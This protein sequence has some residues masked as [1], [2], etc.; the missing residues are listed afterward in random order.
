MT[1]FDEEGHD[2]TLTIKTSHQALNKPEVLHYDLTVIKLTLPLDFYD[3][4]AFIYIS[5]SDGML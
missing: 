5:L 1:M 3:L 4:T 2:V